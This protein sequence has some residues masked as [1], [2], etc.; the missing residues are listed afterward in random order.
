M[1]KPTLDEREFELINIIGAELGANQRDI[2]RLLDLSLGL[3]NMLLKRVIEKGYIRIRQLNSKKVEYLL[4]P[5]GFAEK[6]RKSIKYTLKTIHSISVIKEKIKEVVLP[7]Y[8]K[9]ERH[10]VILGKSDLAMMIEIVFKQMDLNDYHFS[11]IDE[12]TQWEEDG[13]LLICK[14]SMQVPN[15]E[16]TR[17]LDLL[18]ELATRNHFI[19]NKELEEVGV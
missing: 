15:R 12:L 13:F 3:T 16:K 2:S 1:A 10:F 11:Y 9:G 8:E 7:L 17:S 6:T 5:K 18:R 19:N 14:E 4:T